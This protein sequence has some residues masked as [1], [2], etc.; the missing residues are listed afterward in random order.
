MEFVYLF[1]MKIRFTYILIAL[2]PGNCTKDKAIRDYRNEKLVIVLI[3]GARWDETYGDPLHQYIPYLY[4]S[5]KTQGVTFNYFYNQGVTS[6]VPG[7]TAIMTGH[8]ES[9]AND[10]SQIPQYPGLPQ[11]FLKKNPAAKVWIVTSKDKVSVIKN[12]QLASWHNKY[13]ANA[14]C[15]LAQGGYRDDSI[16]FENAKNIITQQK[17]DF[18]FIQFKEPD[19]AAHTGNWNNYLKGITDT[20]K[21]TWEIWKL[22]QQEEAY[23]GKTTFIVTNDHGRHMNSVFGGYT[24]HGD[25]CAGCRRISLF[26]AGP[27]IKKDKFID[28]SYD[29]RSIHKTVCRMFDLESQYGSGSVMEEIFIE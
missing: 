16:T 1:L 24:G 19:A 5:L 11:L 4:D 21:Y 27:D 9:I 14:D 17:P 12:C 2:L 25:N 10:G 28:N 15:G 18:I 6:T 8:Y 7:H 29:Q 23:R 26:I 3:D 13:I 22:I 20:D